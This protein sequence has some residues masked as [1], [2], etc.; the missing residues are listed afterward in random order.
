MPIT[1]MPQPKSGQ[2]LSAAFFEQIVSRLLSRIVGGKNISVRTIGGGKITIDC[3]APYVRGGGKG[4]GKAPFIAPSFGQ[5]PVAPE[6]GPGDLGYTEDH[7]NLYGY[8]SSG[9]RILHPFLTAEAPDLIGEQDGDFWVYGGVVYQ[10]NGTWAPVPYFLGG[11]GYMEDDAGNAF[12]VT[13]LE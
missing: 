12:L 3:T 2:P 6:A 9:W 1:G 5:L 13:H 7:G 10:L 8:R 11:K 4:G